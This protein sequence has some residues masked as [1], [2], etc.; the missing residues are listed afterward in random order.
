M[1][2]TGAIVITVWVC[3]LWPVTAWAC[4]YPTPLRSVN[5]I[6]LEVLNTNGQLANHQRVRLRR[7]VDRIGPGALGGALEAELSWRDARAV[8]RGVGVAAGLAGGGGRTV[9]PDLRGSLDRIR[10][11]IQRTC[12]GGD[13]ADNAGGDEASSAERGLSRNQGSGGRALTFGEGVVR[14]SMT[15]SIY[16]LFLVFLFGLR[17]AGKA[18][19]EGVM[20]PDAL[21]PAESASPESRP[22]ADGPPSQ[23]VPAGARPPPQ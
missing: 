19:T 15:F 3:A 6:L 11:G 7:A 4:A 22:L 21:D 8:R 16:M 5:A 23:E 1:N 9:D 18:R 17:R 14:L 10:E 20:D 13:A 2:R 12:S